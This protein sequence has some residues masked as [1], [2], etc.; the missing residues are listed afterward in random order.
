MGHLLSD[1]RLLPDCPRN[2]SRWKPATIAG[3][4][5]WHGPSRRGNAARRPND[6]KL[7][8]V[9]RLSYLSPKT[10]VKPSPIHGRGLFAGEAIAKGELVCIK[11]G[12]VFDRETLAQVEGD[13]G[14]AEIQIADGHFIGPLLA[15][16]REG[17]M[18]FSNHSC[19][20]NLGVQGQIVFV[21]MRDIAEGEELTHDWA[22]TDDGTYQMNCNC[23]ARICRKVITGQDWRRPELQRRYGDYMSWYLLRKIAAL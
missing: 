18:I 4:G 2:R 9:P 14:P 12:H 3:V 15:E 11:G 13:L 19:E 22:M 6:V 20:P 10:L 21:A 23:G 5:S 17:S 1:R 8:R 16:E 7:P